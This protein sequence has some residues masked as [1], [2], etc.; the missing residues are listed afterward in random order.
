MYTWWK[1]R[2]C[3][4]GLNEAIKAENRP[5]AAFINYLQSTFVKSAPKFHVWGLMTDSRQKRPHERKGNW[6]YRVAGYRYADWR[7][8]QPSKM[9]NFINR[10]RLRVGK[11][12]LKYYMRMY[13]LEDHLGRT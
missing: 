9:L 1:N 7:E 8:S 10:T 4:Q 13:G 6:F 3:P 2:R 12:I 5:P 11:C